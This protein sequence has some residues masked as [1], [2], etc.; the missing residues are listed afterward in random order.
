MRSKM[1]RFTL[2]RFEVILVSSN[3]KTHRFSFSKLLFRL[4]YLF[5]FAFFILLGYI[6]LDYFS[7]LKLETN[8]NAIQRENLVIK[9]EAKILQSNL[10][11]L[12]KSL[13]KVK[14][15]SQKV[16]ELVSLQ[17]HQ[18]SEQTGIGPLSPKEYSLAQARK[19]DSERSEKK[20]LQ[21]LPFGI[22]VEK[23]S[24]RGVFND[25]VEI[26]DASQNRSLE[27]RELLTTLNQKKTLLTSVPTIMPVQGWIASRYGSRL[28][29]FTGENSLHRGLDIAA[30]TGTPIYAPADGV[31]IFSGKKEGFGNFI[32][33]AHYGSGVI[34]RYGHNTHNF[35]QTGQKVSRGDQIASVGSTGNTT[36]PHLHYEAWV[37][38]HPVNPQKFILD[39]DL[40]L[41]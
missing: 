33:I 10:E 24:F 15:Y 1:N 37:N 35:V 22:D 5:T 29:P 41:F 20:P 36:G 34:T 31:V 7:L 6:S 40:E 3:G 28:S 26:Y 4:T 19:I 23:L 27:L 11:E 25:L 18:V 13:R 9:S 8:Y 17:V 32:T 39:S 38:G 14:D 21:A 16:G 12:K 2:R 30:P